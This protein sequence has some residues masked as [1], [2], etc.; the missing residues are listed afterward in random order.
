[1]NAWMHV[2]GW[3]LVHFVWQGALL[4]V[5]AAVWSCVS[6]AVN[7][8]PCDTPLPA[9]AM[10]QM[11]LSQASLPRSSKRPPPASRQRACLRARRPTTELACCCPFR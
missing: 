10:R 6:V 3:V 7:R 5:A 11:I 1:M 9:V 2:A 4:A 8:L